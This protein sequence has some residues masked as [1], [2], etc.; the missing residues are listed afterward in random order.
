[1]RVF[2]ILAILLL[3]IVGLFLYL[4]GNTFFSDEKE[5]PPAS[6]SSEGGGGKKPAAMAKSGDE[7]ASDSTDIV[8]PAP[9]TV[10]K[11]QIVDK[12]LDGNDASGAK[13]AKVRPSFDVVRINENCNLLAAGRAVPSAVVTIIAGEISLGSATASTGGEWVYS[14]D[15]PLAAGSQTINLT[16]KN[17]DGQELESARMVIMNVPDCKKPLS[18]REPAIAMLAPLAGAEGHTAGGTKLLQVPPAKGDVS[19][20]KELNLGAVD[21]DDKGALELSGKGQPGRHV[22]VYMDNQPV[23]TA[24]VGED[25]T[26]VLRPDESIPAGN[27]KLRIDQVDEKGKV[28]SR[29]ELPFQKAPASDVMLAKK[30]G[31]LKA[32]VQPG[33]SLWRIA[34]RVYGEGLEYTVIYQ[35]NQDQIR[36][37]DLIYPGQIFALPDQN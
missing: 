12:K 13:L 22:Q 26:W 18:E 24:E 8:V 25:G 36:D 6:A 10:T 11:P 23:G 16:A 33:N 21:Y 2:G 3:I 5:A 7:E 31:A 29:V 1:M 35:A 9:E 32:I 28:I 34:R 14:S 37:P 30:D 17:P 4:R 27:H 15:K 19:G 20:A